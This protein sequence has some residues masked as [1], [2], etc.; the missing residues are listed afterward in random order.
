MCYF[1]GKSSIIFGKNNVRH[2]Q[3]IS[4]PICFFLQKYNLIQT[5]YQV[6]KF[7]KN[8]W[9]IGKHTSQQR[10]HGQEVASQEQ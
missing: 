2:W 1:Q 5:A 3:S 6:F 8:N 9:I 7:M 10:D 4:S